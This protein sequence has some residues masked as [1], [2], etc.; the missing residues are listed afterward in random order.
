MNNST[1]LA[2]EKL[3]K[4]VGGSSA[5]AREAPFFAL[6]LHWNQDQWTYMGCGGTLVSNRHVLTVGHCLEGRDHRQDAVLIHAYQPFLAENQDVPFHFSRVESYSLHPSYQVSP[7]H[8][9]VAVIT[10][11]EP[12]EALDIFPPIRLTG[13]STILQDG[14]IVHIYGFGRSSE[15]SDEMV[16]TLQVAQVPFISQTTCRQ[17]Y[18][19]HLLYSDMICAGFMPQGGADACKGDSGGPMVVSIEKQIY[20]VGSVSWGEG[21]GRQDKPGVYT[22]T[23]YH[24]DWIQG[25]VCGDHLVGKSVELCSQTLTPSSTSPSLPTMTPLS[26]TDLPSMSPSTFLATTA[27]CGLKQEGEV[28]LYGGQCC[29][30]VCSKSPADNSKRLCLLGEVG[31]FT[32]A[33]L[34]TS[35]EPTTMTSASSTSEDEP[36]DGEDRKGKRKD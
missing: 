6:L 28:C 3:A 5:G 27:V 24:F 18:A 2:L 30:G 33:P 8:N 14:D 35:Q 34:A 7:N 19:E 4:V 21:C 17:Y 9:D 15:E 29:S 12:V 20:Q 36:G 10:L 26:P 16:D 11:S 32:A 23:Q 31:E 25:E 1:P 22:S 13:P